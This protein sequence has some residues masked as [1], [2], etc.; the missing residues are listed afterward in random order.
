MNAC[1]HIAFFCKDRLAQ[2]RFLTRH[3]GFKRCRVFQPGQ[4]DEFVMLRLGSMC[5][6]L[7]AA[8]PG[9]AGPNADETRLGFKHLALTVPD[10]EAKIKELRADGIE[11]ENIIDCDEMSK[12]LRICFFADPEGNRIEIMEG[13]TDEEDP[14]AIGNG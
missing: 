3:F 4:E 2:E 7:F 14:P 5:V 9:A 13:W 10:L 11:P 1:H 6:E 12:G 8:P